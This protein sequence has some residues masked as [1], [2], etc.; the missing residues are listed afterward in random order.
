[1][2]GR[3]IVRDPAICHGRPTFRGTRILVADILWQV[4]RGMPWA[5]I[6]AEWEGRFPEEA[7]AEAID[8]A[9]R[10]FVDHADDVLKASA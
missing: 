1:M 9:T 7:I 3:Y 6:V 2:E 5:T 8:L 10:A 4:A